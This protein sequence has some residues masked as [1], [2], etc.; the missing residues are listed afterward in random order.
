MKTFVIIKDRYNDQHAEEIHGE[1]NAATIKKTATESRD[2][3]GFDDDE[4]LIIGLVSATDAG[5]ARLKRAKREDG[6]GG[7]VW[8]FWLF[9]DGTF[10]SDD[11][12]ELG[13]K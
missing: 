13:A 12:D 8:L 11:L 3:F 6:D 4:T 10:E 9:A 2:R 7:I 5:A 1:A